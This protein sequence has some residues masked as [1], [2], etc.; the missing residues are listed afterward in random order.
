MKTVPPKTKAS[1]RRSFAKSAITALA[2]APIASLMARAN[3]HQDQPRAKQ[4][5]PITIGGGGSVKLK[6]DENYYSPGTVGNFFKSGD[7]LTTVLIINEE[8]DVL[9]NLYPVVEGKN[10]TVTVHC[11]YRG[12][13]SKIEIDSR[14]AVGA[15]PNQI[16]IRFI[17]GDFPYD[18]VKKLRYNGQRKITD[19]LEVRNNDT[20]TSTSYPVPRNGKVGIVAINKL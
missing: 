19:P 11:K 4:S 16:Q 13:N 20:N 17:A 15:Q 1:S 3:N 10:C 18:N 14:P 5:S 2:A 6:F 12:T 8:H 7:E 9:H